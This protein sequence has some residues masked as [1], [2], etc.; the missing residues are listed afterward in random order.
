[1][2]RETL[3]TSETDSAGSTGVLGHF[4]MS[5]DQVVDEVR[6]RAEYAETL[7]P[8]TPS[9]LAVGN[10]AVVLQVIPGLFEILKGASGFVTLSPLTTGGQKRLRL[11]RQVTL[12]S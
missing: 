6:T 7:A 9:T 3:C 10:N 2:G 8:T 5:R 4:E 12:T 1:M 11:A